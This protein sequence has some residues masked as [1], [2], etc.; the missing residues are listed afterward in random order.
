MR[1]GRPPL[2]TEHVKRLEGDDES[3]ER[4][5][6]VLKTITGELTTAEACERL[7]VGETQLGRLRERAL[8]GALAALEPRPVGRPPKEPDPEA[9][10]I[11]E[12]EAE[13]QDLKLDLRAAQ[14]REEIAL[15]MPHLRKPAAEKKRPANK[16]RRRMRR[17]KK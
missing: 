13:V 5:E 17:R 15:V 10:R 14:I 8:Q 12:L 4:L 3:K 1:R 16:R 7:G 11:A 2:G 6:L 9:E